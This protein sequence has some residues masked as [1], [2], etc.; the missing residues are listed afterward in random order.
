MRT[1]YVDRQT[2]T[3]PALCLGASA[4][5]QK[6]AAKGSCFEPC[7]SE[8]LGLRVGSN[9]EGVSVKIIVTYFRMRSTDIAT[10]EWWCSPIEVV[11]WR[12]PEPLVS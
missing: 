12:S 2:Y 3:Y 7:P 11:G 8:V 6:V 1:S 9:L 5:R 10:L 4:P